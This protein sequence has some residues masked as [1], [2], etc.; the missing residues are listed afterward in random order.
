MCTTILLKVN[1]T[2]KQQEFRIKNLNT[3]RAISSCP[4]ISSLVHIELIIMLTSHK[5]GTWAQFIS[6]R[7][8]LG[9][10]NWIKDQEY[11]FIGKG[12]CLPHT[13]AHPAL[14]IQNPWAQDTRLS[15]TPQSKL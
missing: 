7:V 13:R 4:H 14:H 3:T 9:L 8:G 11:I 12:L 10:L 6:V 15:N 1:I 2:L 5:V